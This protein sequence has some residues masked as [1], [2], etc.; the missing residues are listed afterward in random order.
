VSTLLASPPERATE[1]STFTTVSYVVHRGI[2][3]GELRPIYRN[4]EEPFQK[5]QARIIDLLSWS[6]GWNGYDAESPKRAAVEHAFSWIEGMYEDALTT[7]R[8]WIDPHVIADA[9][10]NVVFEWWEDRRKLTVYVSPETVEY[11]K[12]WGPNIF[13]AMED[14]VVEGAEDRRVLWRWLT[15]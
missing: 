1:E 2:G 7:D 12:V 4:F 5:T 6:E 14:G 15:R 9:H 13:S 11:V 8:G 3:D 10:G